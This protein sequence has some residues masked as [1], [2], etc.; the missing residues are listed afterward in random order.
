MKRILKIFRRAT[1]SV[2]TLYEGSEELLDHEDGQILTLKSEILAT[3]PSCEQVVEKNRVRNRCPL[4]AGYCC[5]FCHQERVNHDNRV[6]ERAILVERELAKRWDILEGVPGLRWC[7][8]VSVLTSV[9]RLRRLL[10]ERDN[11]Q[12]RLPPGR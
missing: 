9:G 3:C 8:K 12:T 1:Q 11:E 4:C 10:Y 6:F 5:D 2:A 7:R